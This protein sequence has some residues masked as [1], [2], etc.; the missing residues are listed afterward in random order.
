[1]KRTVFSKGA[2]VDVHKDTLHK[3]LQE[4]FDELYLA[5]AA[6]DLSSLTSPLYIGSGANRVKID[7][8][9][10]MT[11]EGD[12]TFHEDISEP[13]T[14]KNLDT[15]PGT[16]DYSY[17]DDWIILEKGGVLATDA[18]TINVKYQLKHATKPGSNFKIHLHW[19]QTNNTV[20]TIEG[21]HRI[22]KNG[23]ATTSAWQNFSA[24]TNNSIYTYVSGDLNQITSITTIDL[25][26]TGLSD[27]IQVR[28]TR[29]DNN[30][31]ADMYCFMCDA[32][33]EGNSLGSNSEYQ[34]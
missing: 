27:I 31:G 12:A 32:H 19:K 5:A 15:T 10:H 3:W 1:M 28:F 20:R 23:Q 26:N 30:N 11:F 24:T 16:A 21:K 2:A 4:M 13:L 18:D 9:G 14:A 33:Y 17:A 25:T 7:V 6:A 8:D 29:T 34:K 22:Q